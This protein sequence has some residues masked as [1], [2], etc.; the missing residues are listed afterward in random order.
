HPADIPEVPEAILPERSAERET[1]F[2]VL[3]KSGRA[4]QTLCNQIVRQVV[5]FQRIVLEKRA[6]IAVRRVSAGFRDEVENR[7]ARL[8]ELRRDDR[9]RDLYFL[10]DVVRNFHERVADG[11]VVGVRTVDIVEAVAHRAALH[12]LRRS[13]QVPAV[14]NSRSRGDHLSEAAADRS[15][16]EE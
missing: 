5:S 3:D 4:L 8:A 6:D 14:D 13:E 15:T 7:A 16:L 9:G 10:D 1:A 12:R 2:E 11:R